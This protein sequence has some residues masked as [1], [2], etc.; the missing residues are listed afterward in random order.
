MDRRITLSLTALTL[1]GLSFTALPQVI[2]FAQSDPFAGTWQLNPAKSEY[3]I[4]RPPKA[5]TLNVQGEGQNRKATLAGFDAAGNTFRWVIMFIHD[6]QPHPAM[7]APR[8]DS[9]VYTPVDDHT[10]G[11]TITKGGQFVQTGTDTVSHDGRTFTITAAGFD[12]NG[13]PTSDISV[14]DKQ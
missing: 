14:Y 1:L 3:N 2:S 11:W 5:I 7:G 9:T 12:V 10:V 6:S 4:G 8:F 13:R